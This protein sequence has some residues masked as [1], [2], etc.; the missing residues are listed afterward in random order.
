[1]GMDIDKL[2]EKTKTYSKSM[3]K[4]MDFEDDVNLEFV[5]MLGGMKVIYDVVTNEEIDMVDFT[6]IL[7]KL[8]VGLI[9]ESREESNEKE[10]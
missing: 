1:M 10:D 5:A 9:L 4:C 2:V 3:I 6:H 7:N 8:V